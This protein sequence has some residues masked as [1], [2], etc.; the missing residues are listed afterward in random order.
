[1]VN[2]IATLKAVRSALNEQLYDLSN[3]L[4]P[5]DDVEHL[6]ERVVFKQAEVSAKQVRFDFLLDVQPDL[7]QSVL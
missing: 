7:Q 2:C 3:C 6:N 5:V 1:M 4:S